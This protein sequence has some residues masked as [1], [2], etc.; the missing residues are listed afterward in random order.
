MNPSST[1]R[2]IADYLVVALDSNYRQARLS[3]NNYTAL[4]P[5]ILKAARDGVEALPYYGGNR[6][7]G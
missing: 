3:P 4:L 1:I 7:T 2:T 5:T 6:I